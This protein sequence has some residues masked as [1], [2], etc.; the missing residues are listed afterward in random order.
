MLE[1]AYRASNEDG[2]IKT[3]RYDMTPDSARNII[4]RILGDQDAKGQQQ[5]LVLRAKENRQ[6]KDLL[7]K[8]TTA[9]SAQPSQLSSRKPMVNYFGSNNIVTIEDVVGKGIHQL[10]LDTITSWD[11]FQAFLEARFG[12]SSRYEQVA[13]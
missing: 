4:G 10:R 12:G 13:N 1:A 7:I 6:L 11:A 2:N 5:Q 8:Y 9:I 3:I